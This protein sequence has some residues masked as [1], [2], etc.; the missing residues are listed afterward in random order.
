MMF[1]R[2]SIKNPDLILMRQRHGNHAQ[3]LFLI[4]Q[5]TKKKQLSETTPIIGIKLKK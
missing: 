2:S 1:R 4:G 3:F 5:Y